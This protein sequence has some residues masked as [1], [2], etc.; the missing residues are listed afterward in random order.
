MTALLAML[1]T[2]AG[3]ATVTAEPDLAAI[4]RKVAE[5]M[6]RTDRNN[7]GMV[8]YQE[9]VSVFLASNPQVPP[10]MADAFARAAFAKIDTNGDGHFDKLE[11]A[12]FI[13]KN[14]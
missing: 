4:D 6:R 9:F 12:L 11:L 3:G 5:E 14:G 10:N 7:D 1:L 13:A 2:L 8:S